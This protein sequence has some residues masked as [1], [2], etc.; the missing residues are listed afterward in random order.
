MRA[1]CDDCDGPAIF[2]GGGSGKCSACHGTGASTVV[3]S[4]VNTF[5]P[6]SSGE[7]VCEKCHGSGDCPTCRGEGFVEDDE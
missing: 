5:N 2:S 6:F 7:P 1:K 3:E 4:L